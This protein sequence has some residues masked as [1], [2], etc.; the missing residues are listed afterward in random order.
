MTDLEIKKNVSEKAI[1]YGIPTDYSFLYDDLSSNFKKEFERS[2]DQSEFGIPI[3]KY[4]HKNGNWLIV[5]T[6]KLAVKSDTLSLIRIEQIKGFKVPKS[7]F[8]KAKQ[9][10][11]D[12]MLRKFEYE[13]L[14]INYLNGNSIDVWLNKKHDYYGFW[15]IMIR[16]LNLKK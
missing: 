10:Q 16:L 1:K 5:G 7:E 6:K 4:G 11:P 8:E 2:I 15:H 3:V 9:N 14:T 13:I 12:R